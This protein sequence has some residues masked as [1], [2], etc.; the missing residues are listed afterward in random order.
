MR[1]ITDVIQNFKLHWTE[2][3]EAPAVTQTP[4]WRG[5]IATES[6]LLHSALLS[7]PRHALLAERRL[8]WL[9]KLDFSLRNSE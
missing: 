1:S 7:S 4:A 8:L 6:D 5:S 2:E 3:L 9:L